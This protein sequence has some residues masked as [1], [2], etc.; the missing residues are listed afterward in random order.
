MFTGI[1]EEVGTIQDVLK[2]GGGIRFRI[3]APETSSQVGVDDSVAINGICQTIVRCDSSSFDVQAV[4]ETLKKTAMGSYVNEQQVN[5]ELPVRLSDRLGGHLVSGHVDTTGV[6][7]SLEDMESSLLVAVSFPPEFTRYCIPVGSITVDG[8]SLTIASLKENQFVV[9]LIP[10]T[11]GNTTLGALVVGSRVN[12]EFDLVGKYI[13]SLAT[14]RG[15]K[16]QSI[17]W[18]KLQNWGYGG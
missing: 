8:V 10:H 18:E 12:L 15:E 7:D 14:A 11:L 2:E 5:L 17:T 3:G 1:I 16:K 9:S 6:V 4:E 13:E